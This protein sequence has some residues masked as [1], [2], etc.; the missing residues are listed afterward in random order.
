MGYIAEWW[1]SYSEEFPGVTGINRLRYGVHRELE[2]EADRLLKLDLARTSSLSS[3][4]DILT[5]SKESLRRRK[6]ILV[7][8]GVPD[9]S[10]RQGMYTRSY[11]P[12]QVHLNSRDGISSGGGVRFQG[13]LSTAGLQN[14]VDSMQ[15][16]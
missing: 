14:F 2:A 5:P 6:E 16:L 11:N 10:V 12:T 9:P 8:S 4:S 13:S 15:S 7:P 1:R 3:R